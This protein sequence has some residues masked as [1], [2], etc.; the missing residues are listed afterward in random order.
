MHNISINSV[1]LK[2][3]LD[4]ESSKAVEFENYTSTFATG[5]YELIQDHQENG[6]DE[7]NNFVFSINKRF[8]AKNT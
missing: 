4:L 5:D 2:T 6:Q 3:T 1:Y 7:G 8:W